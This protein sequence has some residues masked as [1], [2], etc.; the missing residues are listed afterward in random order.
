MLRRLMRDLEQPKGT[1]IEAHLEF[2]VSF[3]IF[4]SVDL[5]SLLG[6]RRL[7][8]ASPAGQA[9]LSFLTAVEDVQ[10]E[11]AEK[12][13]EEGYDIFKAR[14]GSHTLSSCSV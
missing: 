12:F 5:L 10:Q 9:S 13:A 6:V 14:H 8:I 1:K 3:V 7:K 11:L 4:R 2:S